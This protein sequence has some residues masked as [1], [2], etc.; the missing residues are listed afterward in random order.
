MQILKIF[1][2]F[3][4]SVLLLTFPLKKRIIICAVGHLRFANQGISRP[5]SKQIF[6]S[7]CMNYFLHKY[8]FLCILFQCF[9]IQLQKNANYS[10]I[11]TQACHICMFT[12][13]CMHTH[14]CMC[15]RTYTIQRFYEWAQAYCSSWGRIGS[16][17]VV[18]LSTW[19]LE[20]SPEP[21]TP[22]HTNTL[23]TAF[24]RIFF[25]LP[26]LPAPGKIHH[27]NLAKEYWIT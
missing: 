21:P 7:I 15:A 4:A 2:Y 14:D 24:P 26:P 20:F 18:G 10:C 22:M 8:K 3:F 5:S 23:F 16:P 17:Q 1:K 6:E 13:I 19:I 11:W 9:K 25:I 12:H 27:T